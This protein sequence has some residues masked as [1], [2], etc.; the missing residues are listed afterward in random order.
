MDGG[1]RRLQG[2][3]IP[4]FS[5]GIGLILYRWSAL[6]T[7]VENEW[8]GRDSR[9][10]ADQLAADILPW[11]GDLHS[12]KRLKYLFRGVLIAIWKLPKLL[13]VRFCY[14]HSMKVLL[15]YL[16]EIGWENE[17]IVNYDEEDEEEDGD[18]EES[19]IGDD[20]SSNMNVDTPKYE[21][22]VNSVNTQVSSPLPTVSGEADDGWIAVSNRRNKGRKN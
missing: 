6:R 11:T 15:S 17:V 4:M 14:F 22:N 12:C 7:A 3:S 1:M 10:K 18:N 13:S 9:L 16:I 20:N 8:G 19:V 2:E 21:S 5:E